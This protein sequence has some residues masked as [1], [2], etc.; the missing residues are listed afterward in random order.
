MFLNLTKTKEGPKWGDGTL[1]ENT[2][3]YK[4][5]SSKVA[6][7]TVGSTIFILDSVMNINDYVKDSQAYYF[8]QKDIF[9]L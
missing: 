8:C 1:H 5:V 9:N 7:D 2:E 3:Y 4:H 6:L